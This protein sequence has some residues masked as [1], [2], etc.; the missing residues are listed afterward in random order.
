MLLEGRAWEGLA[1][2]WTNK[3]R[4]PNVILEC[5]HTQEG[6]RYL[7]RWG[8]GFWREA[9][10]IIPVKGA[11]MLEVITGSPCGGGLVRN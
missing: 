4:L 5:C 3:W 1:Y 6:R 8:A 7:N 2:S 9:Q 11:E 10:R